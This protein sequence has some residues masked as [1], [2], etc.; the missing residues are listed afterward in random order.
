MIHLRIP[1]PLCEHM[2]ADLV[3]PHRVAA[4]R[5]GFARMAVGTVNGES[6]LL[7]KSYWAVPDEQYIDD[8]Y[9]GARINSAA[10]R[11]AMQDVLSGGGDHGLFHVHRHPRRGRTG[12]SKT[13]VAEIPKLVNSFRNVGPNVPH[14]LLV[15]TPD[16]ALAFALLPG[17]D[18]LAQ[19][20][21]I[22]IVGY[23]TEILT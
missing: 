21:K 2:R 20:G 17:A 23:P 12:L 14:G 11:A 13:D 4:E 15:L 5:I 1:R 6:L 22:S 18:Q 16:H 7:L 8:P 9:V 3:R 10:I 19:V